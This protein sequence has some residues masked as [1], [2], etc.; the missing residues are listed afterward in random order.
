MWLKLGIVAAAV[1]A[2]WFANGWRLGAQIEER[3]AELA[4]QAAAFGTHVRAEENRL[5]ALASDNDAKKTEELKNALA[6]IDDLRRR[7]S[8]NPSVLRIAAQCPKRPAVLPSP[9]SSPGVDDAAGPRLTDAAQRDYFVLRERIALAG[10]MIE[11]LQ[12]HVREQCSVAG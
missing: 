6:E 4:E 9:D 8:A 3:R 11:G 2:G 12:T 7:A 10:K 1:A 5:R